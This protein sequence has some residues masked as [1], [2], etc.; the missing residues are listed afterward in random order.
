MILI[1][2]PHF[3]PQSNVHI[4][5][6]WKVLFCGLMLYLFIYLFLNKKQMF[7]F[8][9]NTPCSCTYL[10]TAHFF[11]EVIQVWLQNLTGTLDHDSNVNEN[12]SRCESVLFEIVALFMETQK[13]ER[14]DCI[15]LWVRCATKEKWTEEE[16]FFN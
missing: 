16:F 8:K 2:G 7:L 6:I 11:Y 12:E 14:R 9:H 13:A 3:F 5:L 1:A 15:I 10:V 4:F